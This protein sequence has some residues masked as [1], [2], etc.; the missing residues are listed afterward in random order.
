MGPSRPW[1]RQL[2]GTLQGQLQ[3]ATYLA[4]FVGFTGASIAGLWIGQRNL[5]DSTRRDLNQSAE[6]IQTCLQ[7]VGDQPQLLRQELL[8]HSNLSR[9]LWIE[10]ANGKLLLPQSDHLPI[11]ESSIRLAMSANP[12]RVVGQLQRVELK[13]R[14]YL[15][16]L[17]ERFPSG[18]M[19]WVSQEVSENQ[20]AL[21]S[22]LSLMILIWGSCLAIT[23]LTVTWLVRRID[24]VLAA[25]P[26]SSNMEGVSK[27]QNMEC[28]TRK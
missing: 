7:E 24:A 21:S 8:L 12:R 22:Y 18:E 15:S 9:Q 16:E 6:A 25:N 5:I 26:A 14:T 17:V 20:R 1:R 4:V 28:F 13:D 3:L 2:L 23:L 27:T 10:D 19:L 11:K